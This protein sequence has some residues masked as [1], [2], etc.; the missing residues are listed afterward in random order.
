MNR[1]LHVVVSGLGWMSLCAIAGCGS[2]SEPV[3]AAALTPP[4]VPNAIKAPADEHVGGR[5]HVVAAETFACQQQTNADG[6]T[7]GVTYAW[8]TVAL[9]AKL[10]DWDTNATIGMHT[11]SPLPTFTST[12]GSSVVAMPTAMV[13]S[14]NGTGGPWLLLTA[15]SHSGTGIFSSATSLQRINTA[16][17]GMPPA[18]CDATTDPSARPIVNGS[19]D[20]YYYAK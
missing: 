15:V 11:H 1:M 14:P 10:L 8:T 16:G 13:P 19:S 18:T 5:F 2:S 6:G 20:F 4:D 3:D 9:D 17:G 12:D 7:G